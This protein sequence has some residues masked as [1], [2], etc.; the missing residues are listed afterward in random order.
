MSRWIGLRAQGLLLAALRESAFVPAL[1]ARNRD[2]VIRELARAVAPA[3]K[4]EPATLE[5]LVLGRE[6]VMATGIGQGVAIPHAVL[7]GLAAPVAALGL[8]EPGVDFGA[9]DG[10]PARIAVLVVTPEGEDRAQLELLTEASRLFADPGTR[11]R[12]A[13]ARSFEE[14]SRALR[15][16]PIRGG[17]H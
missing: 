3:A 11:Q 13:R 8:V 15:D 9:P 5:G 16:A 17:E 2:E 12:V 10:E 14:L 4:V 7:P 1:A 6:A